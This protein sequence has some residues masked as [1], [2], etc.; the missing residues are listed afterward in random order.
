[1]RLS[2]IGIVVVTAAVGWTSSVTAWTLLRFVAGVLSACALVATTAW[3]LA[4]SAWLGRTRLAG[5]LFAGVGVG[6]AGA[7][8]FCLLA[9][10]PGVAAERLWIELAVL[11]CA[12]ALLPLVVSRIGSPASGNNEIGH[13]HATEHTSRS[14]TGA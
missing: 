3:T 1:L 10:R 8:V 5:A 13:I 7:G 14:R 6:I 11:S 12:A 2:L 9:A 4:W